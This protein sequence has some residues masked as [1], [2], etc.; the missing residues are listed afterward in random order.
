MKD[1]EHAMFLLHLHGSGKT[2]V[3]EVI[4]LLIICGIYASFLSQTI[5]VKHLE[6]IFRGFD[7]MALDWF[8]CVLG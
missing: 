3:L 7:L 6:G 8:C 4:T 1:F 2:L 5:L